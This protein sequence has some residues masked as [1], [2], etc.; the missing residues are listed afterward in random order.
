MTKTRRSTSTDNH[1]GQRSV[2]NNKVHAYASRDNAFRAFRRARAAQTAKA[3]RLAN[4]VDD[5]N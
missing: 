4:A 1:K 2:R 5:Q 3:L